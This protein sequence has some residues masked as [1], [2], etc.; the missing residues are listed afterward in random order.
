M[1]NV[2]GAVSLSFDINFS[3]APPGSTWEPGEAHV[4]RIVVGGDP[5][6]A[7]GPEENF[8]LLTI[9]GTQKSISVTV[10]NDVETNV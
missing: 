10:P 3:I 9:D 8:V 4:I 2:S 5:D 6:T 7:G 1:G